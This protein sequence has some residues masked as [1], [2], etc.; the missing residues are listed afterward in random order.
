MDEE[1]RWSVT[2]CTT[3]ISF[4][5]WLEPLEMCGFQKKARK[6]KETEDQLYGTRIT[7]F[8]LCIRVS[9]FSNLENMSKQKSVSSSD[10]KYRRS[11]L[12]GSIALNAGTW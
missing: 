3:F 2:A 6:E 9:L 12:T 4:K 1:S 10:C 11:H 7:V 8:Y 5:E